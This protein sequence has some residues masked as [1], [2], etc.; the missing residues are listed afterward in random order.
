MNPVIY[1]AEIQLSGILHRHHPIVFGDVLCC[2]VKNCCFAGVGAAT[3]QDSFSVD[4]GFAHAIN[5]GRLKAI[6]FPSN[7]NLA[8]DADGACDTSFIDC[9]SGN[10]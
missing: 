1:M 6:I 5:F 3:E 2:E 7:G 4:K 10:P 9:R 8:F